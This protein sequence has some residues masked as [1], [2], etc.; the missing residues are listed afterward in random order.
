MRTACVLGKVGLVDSCKCSMLSDFMGVK[1]GL[2]DAKYGNRAAGES[3]IQCC[4]V[5]TCEG[6]DCVSIG[7]VFV[8]LAR[9]DGKAH[10]S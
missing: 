9:D 5:H 3:V 2:N 8:F 4:R 7:N 1:G 10:F 6:Q